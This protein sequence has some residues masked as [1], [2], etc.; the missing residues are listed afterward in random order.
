MDYLANGV[1]EFIIEEA[2]TKEG[3]LCR[4]N[5]LLG[6][7]SYPILNILEY[8]S[9]SLNRYSRELFIKGSRVLLTEKETLFLESLFRNEGICSSE[10]LISYI[11][12]QTA[13]EY[14]Q[15]ALVMTISRLKKRIYNQTGYTLI[16]SKYGVGYYLNL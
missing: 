8:K 11:S 3:L 5:K 6:Y 10:E 1:D 14:N 7:Y 15:R 2:F 13:Q 12:V 16:K 4:F 9:L